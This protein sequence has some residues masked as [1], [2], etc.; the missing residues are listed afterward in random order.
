MQ[1]L[2]HRAAVASAVLART[3]PR[4]QASAASTSSRVE[5]PSSANAA[6][7]SPTSGTISSKRQPPVDERGHRLLVGGVEDARREAT[8]LPRGPGERDGREAGAVDRQE[9]ERRDVAE[10]EVRPDAGEAFAV[11]ERQRDRHAHVGNAHLGDDRSVVELD[12]AVHDAG[13]MDGDVDRR[14]RA[15]RRGNAPR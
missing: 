5:A 9:L 15:R 2:D 13:R 1:E 10:V 14:S 7:A 12:P 4:A 11:G 3:K 8:A 6:S